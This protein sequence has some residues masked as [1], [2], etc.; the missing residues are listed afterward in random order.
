MSGRK[1]ETGKVYAGRLGT[2]HMVEE[3][4]HTFIVYRVLTQQI[5]DKIPHDKINGFYAGSEKSV[6][7]FLVKRCQVNLEKYND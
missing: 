2:M 4:E 5:V 7:D 6:E 3:K 1:F